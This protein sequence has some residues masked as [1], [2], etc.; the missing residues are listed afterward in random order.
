MVIVQSESSG[1]QPGDQVVVTPI[2]QPTEGTPVVVQSTRTLP[3]SQAPPSTV[4]GG[5]G[6]SPLKKTEAR[7]E[8]ESEDRS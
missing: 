4:D 1:L 7:W 2:P 3:K 5:K 6:E 8:T